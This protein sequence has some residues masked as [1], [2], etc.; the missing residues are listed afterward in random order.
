VD[1][2]RVISPTLVTVNG[3]AE[4][5]RPWLVNFNGI[6]GG[7]LGRQAGVQDYRTVRDATT[8]ELRRTLVTFGG[9]NNT[10][11][12]VKTCGV[13][14]AGGESVFYLDGDCIFDDGEEDLKG[15]KVLW[16]F[17]APMPDEGSFVEIVAVSSCTIKDG[18]LVRMLRP[19][20]ADAVR[21]LRMAQ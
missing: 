2:E 16:P 17:E 3:I 1:G 4:V 11:L 13:V 14:T 7:P 20:S 21:L 6:G 9:A 19:V 18:I 12:L 10:G 8:G 5:P 15:I